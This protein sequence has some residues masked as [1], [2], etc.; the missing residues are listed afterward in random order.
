MEVV[1]EL[2]K[3]GANVDR[4]NNDGWKTLYTAAKT[5]HVDVVRD[6]RKHVASE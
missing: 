6:F 4:A 2:V 1:R 3:H 5:G